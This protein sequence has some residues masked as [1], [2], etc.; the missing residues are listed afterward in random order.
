[1]QRLSVHY[2]GKFNCARKEAN[3]LQQNTNKIITTSL[4]QELVKI[5]SNNNF[6]NTETKNEFK[7]IIHFCQYTFQEFDTEY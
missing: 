5:I 2:H 1:M 4:A 3:E 6:I 7:S